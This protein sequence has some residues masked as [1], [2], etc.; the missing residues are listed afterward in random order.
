MGHER[1]AL[2]LWFWQLDGGGPIERRR[3]SRPAD[4]LFPQQTL[5][6]AAGG[7]WQPLFLD[8]LFLSFTNASAFSP[9]DTLPLSHWAKMLMLVQSASV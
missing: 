9:T 7:R 5:A 8:Y 2:A 1:P 6:G 3:A 4:F